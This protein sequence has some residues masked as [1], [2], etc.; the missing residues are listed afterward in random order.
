[1]DENSEQAQEKPKILKSSKLKHLDHSKVP[2]TSPLHFT[3]QYSETGA[4]P[5]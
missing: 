5:N 3:K 4:E 2:V 1:M